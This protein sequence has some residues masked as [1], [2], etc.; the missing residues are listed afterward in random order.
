MSLH[1][2]LGQRWHW[3][4]RARGRHWHAP[5]AVAPAA[6]RLLHRLERR[7]RRRG[8]IAAK[9]AAASASAS[10]ASESRV[11]DVGHPRVRLQNRKELKD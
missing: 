6:H 8:K 10:A 9:R 4:A 2:A 1:S 3:A 7:E 11:V 5:A